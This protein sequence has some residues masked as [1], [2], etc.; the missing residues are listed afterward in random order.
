MKIQTQFLTTNNSYDVNEPYAIVVHNTDNYA[1]TATAKAHAK[2]WECNS[3][4]KDKQQ[5]FN[6]CGNVRQCRM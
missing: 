1:A 5:K 2:L 6:L 4:W 3:V